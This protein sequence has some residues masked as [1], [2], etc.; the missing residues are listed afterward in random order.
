[1]E[2]DFLAEEGEYFIICSAEPLTKG[3]WAASALF[4]RKVDRNKEFVP[5]VRHR[6]VQSTFD[7]E[8][9]AVQA[10]YQHACQ[11]IEKGIVGLD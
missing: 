1:M 2:N 8:Q 7:S 9:E 3:K 6:I 10:A 4:E 11:L 5:A